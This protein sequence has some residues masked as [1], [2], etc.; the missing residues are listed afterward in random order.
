M[1]TLC[2]AMFR[3][4]IAESDDWTGSDDSQ[5]PIS[6][7]VEIEAP[8]KWTDYDEQLW[9]YQEDGYDEDPPDPGW[10]IAQL[11]S[12]GVPR[13]Q[14]YDSEAEA[15]LFYGGLEATYNTLMEMIDLDDYRGE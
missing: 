5:V 3:W 11:T 9:E 4:V 6:V 14:S 8:G 2:D 7:L 1:D 13:W 10:Y 12:D 15:R